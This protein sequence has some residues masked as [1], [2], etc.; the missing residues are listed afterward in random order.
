VIK[1]SGMNGGGI[2][3]L[4]CHGS[5]LLRWGLAVRGCKNFNFNWTVKERIDTCLELLA[6]SESLSDEEAGRTRSLH[7]LH[8]VSLVAERVLMS[9]VHLSGNK[10]ESGTSQGVG[11]E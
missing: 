7:L 4:D 5:F 10:T 2:S 3:P 9:G 8:L 11:D 1:I 6:T